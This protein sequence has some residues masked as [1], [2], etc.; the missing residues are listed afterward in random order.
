MGPFEMPLLGDNVEFTILRGMLEP[1]ALALDDTGGF[2]YLVTRHGQLYEIILAPLIELVTANLHEAVFD[3]AAKYGNM[4]NNV[5]F[6]LN[7]GKLPK[8]I[9]YIETGI[10]SVMRITGISILPT[11]NSI[12]P[13][14]GSCPPNYEIDPWYRR[15]IILSN[16][17][18][19]SIILVSTKGLHPVELYVGGY[20]GDKQIIW[21]M[22]VI[23]RYDVPSLHSYLGIVCN[24]FKAPFST[25]QIKLY[26]AEFL[27]K[28]WEQEL[29]LP[30]PSPHLNASR[31]HDI[32]RDLH[33]NST[34]LDISRFTASLNIRSYFDYSRRFD[35]VSTFVEVE[36]D[37]PIPISMEGVG[38][39][40]GGRM[41]NRESPIRFE[42]VG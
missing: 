28:V 9:K 33:E 2:I 21:P 34:L 3:S 27:G 14:D 1:T 18:R 6:D 26:I 4:A 31:K 7:V 41:L 12:L 38:T 23:A 30:V 19:S 24:N 15:R 5:E 36:L 11:V 25:F 29:N 10:R 42:A 17:F 40:R 39:S 22:S 37:Q 20:S 16:A 35:P 13:S 32:I 8:W